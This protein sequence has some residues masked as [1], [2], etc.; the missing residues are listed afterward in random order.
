MG[1]IWS[2]RREFHRVPRSE[3]YRESFR[4]HIDSLGR[5]NPYKHNRNSRCRL[6]IDNSPPLTRLTAEVLAANPA[7]KDQPPDSSMPLPAHLGTRNHENP[8]KDDKTQEK[9]GGS[10]NECFTAFGAGS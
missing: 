6:P 3:L 5:M 9:H 7:T 2:E 8:Q 4:G 10:S 1:R